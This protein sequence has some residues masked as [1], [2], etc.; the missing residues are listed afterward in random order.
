MHM[1]IIMKLCSYIYLFMS[2][3]FNLCNLI[4]I[5]I[6]DFKLL[7]GLSN[8]E[9]FIFTCISKNIYKIQICQNRYTIIYY[10]YMILYLSSKYIYYKLNMPMLLFFSVIGI[11]YYW[12]I[13]IYMLQTKQCFTFIYIWYI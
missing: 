1:I 9:F 5:F 7:K 6:H 4:R 8:I 3:K 2:Y 13:Y 10:I 11:K 12:Y